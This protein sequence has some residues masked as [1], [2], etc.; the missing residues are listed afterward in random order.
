MRGLFLEDAT[1]TYRDDLPEPTPGADDTLV[2]VIKAGICATDV[3]LSRGYMGFT[4]VPGHEFVGIA[5]GGPLDGQRV[6]GDINAA[7][8]WCETCQA[9]D[10]HHCPNRTVLG[11]LQHSGAFAERLCLP[12][13]NLLAVPDAVSSDVATFVEPLAAAFEIGQQLDLHPGQRALVA[14]DGK[15]GLLCAWALHLAGVRVVVAGRHAERSVLLPEEVELR[16]GVLEGE[17]HT[18][19]DLV[20]EATGQPDVLP[21]ALAR[22]RPRG[23]LVLKTTTERPSTVDLSRLVVDEITMVGSRCGPFDSALA[24]LAAGDVP[25]Q[26]L[27]AARYPLVDGVAAFDAA[28]AAGALKILVEVRRD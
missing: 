5:R 23:I 9:G 4:G 19:F 25:V 12:T 15:L 17:V 13:R 21:H 2:E 14:G 26:K 3:A 16:S 22:V 11:I 27:I 24:A 6:V 10:P 8:G 18:R 1:L 28:Q 7:C 20:V